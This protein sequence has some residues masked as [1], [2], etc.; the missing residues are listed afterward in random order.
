M[1]PVAGVAGVRLIPETKTLEG[2]LHMHHIV[3]TQS[4]VYMGSFDH[5]LESPSLEM[6]P[7]CVRYVPLHSRL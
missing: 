6:G 5:V 2:S 1:F 4:Q 3:T 7:F